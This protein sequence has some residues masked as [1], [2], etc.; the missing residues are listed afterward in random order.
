MFK[1]GDRVKC[2]HCDGMGKYID[3]TGEITVGVIYTVSAI[4]VRGTGNISVEGINSNFAKDRFILYPKENTI[5]N[6]LKEI[7]EAES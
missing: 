6:I 2:L 7:D 4:N 5:I 1:V 3:R